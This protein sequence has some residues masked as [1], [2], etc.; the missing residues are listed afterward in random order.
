[1][2][3][4]NSEEEIMER[5]SH[6]SNFE[7]PLQD[8]KNAKFESLPSKKFNDEYKFEETI[9][10][11][12]FTEEICSS[13]E[14]IPYID[15]NIGVNYEAYDLSLIVFDKTEKRYLDSNYVDKETKECLKKKDE[16]NKKVR[17]EKDISEYDNLKENFDWWLNKKENRRKSYE[18]MIP[19]NETTLTKEI[20]NDMQQE[21]NDQ[22]FAASK[23]SICLKLLKYFFLFLLFFIPLF[24]ISLAF[25]G[26]GLCDIQP[27]IPHSLYFIGFF[28][29]ISFVLSILLSL[30]WSPAIAIFLTIILSIICIILT[31]FILFVTYWF[32]DF[33]YLLQQQPP[34][35]PTFYCSDRSVFAYV[36]AI[37]LSWIS[38]GII[39]YLN[40]NIFSKVTFCK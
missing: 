7:E 15:E 29:F 24:L 38:L 17:F 12:M 16:N 40:K 13:S 34:H 28:I 20:E 14:G 26:F 5:S 1:M 36:T 6:T 10:E 30:D 32:S 21:S 39:L 11:K 8:I 35:C 33:Y 19:L 31:G 3:F 18:Q 23:L 25:F 37:L 22:F 2:M 27:T 9:V 4:Q